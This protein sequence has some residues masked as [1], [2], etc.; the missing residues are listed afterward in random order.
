[1][2]TALTFAISKG[3][4]RLSQLPVHSM[5]RRRARPAGQPLTVQITY[6]AGNHAK[7]EQAR[8]VTSRKLVIE[9]T[10]SL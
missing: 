5:I 2:L 1:V 6:T 10:A 3:T 4:D 8:P 7:S 9:S